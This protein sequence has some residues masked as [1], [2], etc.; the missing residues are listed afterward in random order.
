M[1]SLYRNLVKIQNLCTILPHNRIGEHSV[2]NVIDDADTAFNEYLKALGEKRFDA[3]SASFRSLEQIV[4]Q[5][6]RQTGT[7]SPESQH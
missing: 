7:E 3:A 4:H 6:K 5:L 1:T 2:R